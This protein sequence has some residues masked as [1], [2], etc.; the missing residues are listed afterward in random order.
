M[1][2]SKETP[3][4]VYATD[5]RQKLTKEKRRQR[6]AERLIVVSSGGTVMPQE[7]TCA[8]NADGQ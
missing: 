7:W 3:K 1:A 6:H 8:H 5:G 2:I 4:D